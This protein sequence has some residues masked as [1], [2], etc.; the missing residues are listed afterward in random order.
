MSCSAPKAL[1]YNTYRNF[2]IEKLGFTTTGIKLD[3]EYYN[4]N[5]IG[6]QLRRSELDVFINN[7]LLGHSSLDTFIN[8][9]RRDTFLLPIKF[10]VDMKNLLKNTWNAFSENEVTIKLTGRLKVGKANVFM[11]MPVNYEGKHKFSLF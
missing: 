6:L 10:G 5:N 11:N 2:S 7:V 9:P 4:P 8:I 3:L 1:E